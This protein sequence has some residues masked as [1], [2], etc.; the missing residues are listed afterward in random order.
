M[1]NATKPMRRRNF[2]SLGG[3]SL[4]GLVCEKLKAGGKNTLSVV[5]VNPDAEQAVGVQSLNGA[6]HLAKDPQNVGRERSW[7]A[8]GPV[9]GAQAC[10]VPDILE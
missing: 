3:V 7:F 1:A 4:A 5:K 9:E 6:W 10:Q 2:L 8:S